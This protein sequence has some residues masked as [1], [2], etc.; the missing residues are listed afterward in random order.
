M[1][2][3][4]TFVVTLTLLGP[5]LT[6][7]PGARVQSSEKE[8]RTP[9]QRKINSQLL[10][11]I[12]RLQGTAARKQVPPGPTI[13]RIDAKKRALVDVRS[14]VTPAL[15]KKILAAGSAIVSSSTELHSIV[16]WIPLLQLERL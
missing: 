9:A 4:A 1:P 12:Y 14:V 10:Y 3:I 13:V 2:L 8:S 6:H 5:V 16:A 11:E 15:R 7:V